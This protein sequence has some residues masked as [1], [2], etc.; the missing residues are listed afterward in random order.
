MTGVEWILASQL[1]SRRPSFAN[2]YNTL[3]FRN[4]TIGNP[5]PAQL[6]L[7]VTL[8][9]FSKP[10]RFHQT[11]IKHWCNVKIQ[12]PLQVHT[13]DAVGKDWRQTRLAV[14]IP[15]CSS[16]RF[17]QNHW[18]SVEIFNRM[19]QFQMMIPKFSLNLP[20]G[21]WCVWSQGIT[22]VPGITLRQT[23]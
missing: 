9:C 20:K 6:R 3:C 1:D 13:G 23:D 14:H 16:N 21:L 22:K 2:T 4:A 11:I 19:L 8:L 15:T 7:A 17:P 10:Y 12:C 18:E 5:V